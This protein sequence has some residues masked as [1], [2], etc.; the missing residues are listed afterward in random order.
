MSG[1]GFRCFWCYCDWS[2]LII[3]QYVYL[4][5]Y[6]Q[7]PQVNYY[8]HLIIYW[9]TDSS[10]KNAALAAKLLQ[11]QLKHV[12][13]IQATSFAFL[14]W[15]P[16]R[17]IHHGCSG[18]WQQQNHHNGNPRMQG[19]AANISKC[20]PCGLNLLD[21]LEL[22]LNFCYT[23]WLW[24]LRHHNAKAFPIAASLASQL[25][26]FLWLRKDLPICS[27]KCQEAFSKK[28]LD[29]NMQIPHRGDIGHWSFLSRTTFRLSICSDSHQASF[30]KGNNIETFWPNHTWANRWSWSI[31]TYPKSLYYPKFFRFLN[32]TSQSDPF[33]DT[34]RLMV[35]P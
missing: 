25:Q 13:Q 12:Q 15:N 14:C 9:T 3:L 16:H 6:Q 22:I 35:N 19:M 2:I 30:T 18:L 21:T 1:C 5:C 28:V 33:S 27:D 7:N 34:L 23:L 29:Q 31:L 10:W 11:D 4:S 17:M 26:G 8:S 32:V 20:T 24:S